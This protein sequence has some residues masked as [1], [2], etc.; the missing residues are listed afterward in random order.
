VG[1]GTNSRT[2]LAVVGGLA[3]RDGAVGETVAAAAGNLGDEADGT[4]RDDAVGRARGACVGEAPGDTNAGLEI[5]GE[6]SAVASVGLPKVFGGATG[7]GVDSDLIFARA[8][9]TA[10]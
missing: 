8:F 3:R 5:A 9:S 4:R 2:G 6:V 1:D 7:G 10:C